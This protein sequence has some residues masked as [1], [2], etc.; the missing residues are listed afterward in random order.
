MDCEKEFYLCPKCFHI[1][2]AV[3]EHH[4]RPMFRY[5]GFQPGHAQIKP[6]QDEAGN[7]K[8]RAPRWFVEKQW[9]HA[10]GPGLERK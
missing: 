8:S 1:A 10:V 9:P 3:Q 5:A 4:Q 6:V 7:L 2:D